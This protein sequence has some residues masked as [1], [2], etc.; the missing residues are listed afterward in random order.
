MNPWAALID[1]R[2]LVMVSFL[3]IARIMPRTKSEWTFVDVG[4]HA[5]GKG[6]LP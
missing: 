1:S 5:H 2:D 3:E 6:A 4:E